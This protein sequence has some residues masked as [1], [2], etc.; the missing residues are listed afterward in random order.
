MV[1]IGMPDPSRGPRRGVATNVYYCKMHQ[2]RLGFY[3]FVLIY[4]I[5]GFRM[6]QS[7]HIYT[8]PSIGRLLEYHFSMRKFTH[9]YAKHFSRIT[10]H[11]Y[12]KLMWG[13]EKVPTLISSFQIPMLFW[14]FVNCNPGKKA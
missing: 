6:F 5:S 11:E 2:I 8:P 13:S 7:S 1:R 3:N 14:V 10:M 9:A 4:T 12:S